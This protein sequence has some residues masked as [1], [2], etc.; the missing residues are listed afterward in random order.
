MPTFTPAWLDPDDVR[1]WLRLNGAGDGDDQVELERVCVQTEAYVQRCRPE[2]YTD[3]DEPALYEPDGETYQ[4]AVMYASREMRR[5]N[6]PAG[7]ESF[8]DVGVVFTPK[9]DADIE[10]ALRTGNWNKPGFG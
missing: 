5:R 3:S 4:G 10:R 9:F 1:R 8:G 2:W 6:T 7:V